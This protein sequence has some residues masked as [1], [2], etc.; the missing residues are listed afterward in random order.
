MRNVVCYEQLESLPHEKGR[1]LR[2]KFEEIIEALKVD[3][4]DRDQRPKGDEIPIRWEPPPPD[5]VL[6]NTGG[7]S[8]GNPSS[9]VCGGVFRGH[10]G[11]WFEGLSRG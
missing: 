4:Q 2:R 3:R 1:L 10:R 5:W 9:V 11:E 8:K 7:A 6:L